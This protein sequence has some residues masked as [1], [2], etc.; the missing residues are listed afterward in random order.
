M[1][2]G[3]EPHELVEQAVEQHHH[4]AHAPDAEKRDLRAAAVAAAVLAV[5]A[6]MASLLSG[7]AANQAILLQTQAADQWAYFQSTSTKGHLYKVGAALLSAG[8]RAADSGRDFEAQVAKY[9]SEKG[10]QEHKARELEEE[11]AHEFR[12][13]HNYALG[14]A[15][16]Q[17]GVVLASVSILVRYRILLVLSLLAGA[18]GAVS[19]VVGLIA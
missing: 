11:S 8:G 18:A 9:E 19:V 1:E 4:G 15:A 16:F 17:V 3:P 2:E 6:A 10:E 13:H 5:F 14:I 7:H 12:K